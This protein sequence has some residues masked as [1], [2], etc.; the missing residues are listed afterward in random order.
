[1]REVQSSPPQG[2]DSKNAR[3]LGAMPTS[4]KALSN[5]Q[6]ENVFAEPV[7]AA[8]EA[9]RSAPAVQFAGAVK[10]GKFANRPPR[11]SRIGF[12]LR[13]RSV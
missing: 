3:S 4:A 1:M 8:A 6:A 11:C 10:S 5:A 7:E 9:E 2:S 12:P 13:S